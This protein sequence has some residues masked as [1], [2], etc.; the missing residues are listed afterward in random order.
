[1]ETRQFD[2]RKMRK[3][4]SIEDENEIIVPHYN[5]RQFWHY[6]HFKC[7]WQMVTYNITLPYKKTF[8][9]GTRP[10]LKPQSHI[11]DFGPGRA[12][13]HPDLASR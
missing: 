8:L 10:G 13:V 2:D 5:R 6:S 3:Y 12:T 4:V 11:H 1:M 9:L 7:Q